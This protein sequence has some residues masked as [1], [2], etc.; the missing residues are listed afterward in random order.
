MP[1]RIPNDLPAAGTLQ[2][3]NIFVMT[4]N[5]AVS[6]DIRPLE[7][8]LLN[9]MPT[10]VETETQFTRLLGN[11]P[12]Q[13]HL[14]LMQVSSHKSKNV[15]QEHMLTFYKTFDE[16][17]D[18]K[19][20]GMV[21][22]GAPLEHLAYE[23]VDYWEELCQIMEWSKT[24]VHSTIHICWGAFAGLYYHYGID[25][26]RMDEKIFGVFPHVAD[27]KRAILL[28]GFDDVFYVPHSRYFGMDREKVETEPR[29]KILASSEKSGV[30]AVMNEGG[31]QIFITGHSEYDADTLQREYM[32]DKNLGLPIAVPE[33][34][35][36]ND[37]DTQEPLVRW[38]GHAN[39]LFSNWLNY[40]VYQTTPYDIMS[41][42]D[43]EET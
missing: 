27:Y 6:Q 13:V 20:D 7:I 18:R 39:L 25:C 2:Q 8:V 36:P 42:G 5:R 16:L 40:F 12:L 30:Y 33:N 21:I 14:E 15:S 29:L 10:K 9:L 26:I 41:I 31:R 35:F 22:T 1:I 34:Y 43:R 3:E 4:E 23:D 28:R 19:F 17:K 32:R 37:D 24:N 38:R 11:T